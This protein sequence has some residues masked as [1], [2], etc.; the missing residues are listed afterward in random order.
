VRASSK[1]FGTLQLYIK[2]PTLCIDPFATRCIKFATL[3]INHY[4]PSMLP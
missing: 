2:F 1:Q 4:L 3:C